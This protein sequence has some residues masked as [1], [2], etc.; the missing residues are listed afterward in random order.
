MIALAPIDNRIPKWDID[1]LVLRLC[2]FCRTINPS[3]L[4][5]PDKLPVAFCNKCG[6]WYVDHLPPLESI[7]AFYNGYYN[8]HRPSDLSGRQVSL[9]FR[10]AYDSSKTNQQLQTLLKLHVGKDRMRILDVGCGLGKFLLEARMAGAD[11]VG[12]DISPEACEFANN[13]LGI[14]VYKSELHSCA[15]SIGSVDAVVMRDLIEHLIDPLMS[16][17]SACSIL[18]KGGL[19]LLLTP[20]GGEA[21]I[22]AETGSNWVGFRVDLEH[23]QYL[24]PQTINWLSE[25]CGMRIEQLETKGFPFLK[26]VDRMSVR[27]SEI[28]TSIRENAKRI[29]GMRGIVRTLRMIK[30][31]LV[32]VQNDPNLGFYHLCT[33]L[34]KI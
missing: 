30:S 15:S 10:D 29:P 4:I 2:P 25:E 8:T 16:I 22:D 14:K 3:L 12:C 31:E 34:R 33:V 24:S 28:V 21:G 11:V 32:G 7:R 19:L 6:C 20:N 27:K 13:K 5:R 26:D 9:M 17:H 1:R 23:L 18:N